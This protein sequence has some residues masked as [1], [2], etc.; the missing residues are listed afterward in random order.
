MGKKL[1]TRSTRNGTTRGI[2][3]EVAVSKICVA[4]VSIRL[5]GPDALVCLASIASQQNECETRERRTDEPK[6]VD[7]TTAR[8]L[9]PASGRLWNAVTHGR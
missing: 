7:M 4:T 9:D 3:D 1:H 2:S 8:E 6:G 5:F